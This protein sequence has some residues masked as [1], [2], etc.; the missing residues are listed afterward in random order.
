MKKVSHTLLVMMLLGTSQS[1]HSQHL[2]WGAK[3]GFNFASA[4]SDDAIASSKPGYQVGLFF[5]AKFGKVGL[6][7]EISLSNQRFTLKKDSEDAEET[8]T[9]LNVPILLTYYPISQVRLQLG[10]QVGFLI[11]GN[12]KNNSLLM[13]NIPFNENIKDAYTATDVSISAGGGYDFK[14][15]LEVDLRYNVGVKDIS[16]ETQY[17]KEPVYSRMLIVSIGWNFLNRRSAL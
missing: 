7:P 4:Y 1:L 3:T 11:D 12:R 9:Y 13:S 14:F 2:A 15:G 17:S 5:R 16:I 8:F 6:Q 10:P